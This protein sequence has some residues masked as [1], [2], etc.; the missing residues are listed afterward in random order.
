MKLPAVNFADVTLAPNIVSLTRLPL[1][2]L[3]P[4]LID[5]PGAAFAVLIASALTDVV[6][7]WLARKNGQVT[8]LGAIIDPI[9]DKAFALTVVVTLIARRML[10][11]W[12]I[13]ALLAREIF[14]LPL[15]VWVFFHRASDPERRVAASANIPG[16]IATTIQFGAVMSALVMPEILR[17][18]LAASA[19]FGVIA[20]ITYWTRTTRPG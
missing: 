5:N 18:C 7:G 3:F 8:A 6:D 11:L 15:V 12:G 9:A 16:K 4:L 1:A 20:G 10:P 19:V 17:V 14:E 13:P 2:V